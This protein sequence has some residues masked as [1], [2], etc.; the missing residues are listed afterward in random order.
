MRCWNTYSQ[1][2]RQ[3][4]A[5][6]KSAANNKRNNNN[7]NNNA[8]TGKGGPAAAGAAGKKPRA[9]RTG[10]PAKKT[11]EELDSEMADYF[12]SGA[13]PNENAAAAA[14]APAA[15][16]GDAAMEDEIM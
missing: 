14:P 7:N 4:K 8:N 13:N 11:A 12:E 6:P 9:K 15:T 10:R 3:P 16:N 2:N 1:E 5:Q